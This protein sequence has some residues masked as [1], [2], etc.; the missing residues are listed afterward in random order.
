LTYPDADF[1]AVSFIFKIGKRIVLFI[2][3]M[4][5]LFYFQELK[6]WSGRLN[7]QCLFS[8]PVSH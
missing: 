2:F 3:M 8:S 4:S 6:S 5:Q 7:I 1:V